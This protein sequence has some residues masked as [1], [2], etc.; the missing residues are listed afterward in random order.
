MKG[1]VIRQNRSD[2][3]LCG[4]RNGTSHSNAAQTEDNVR[5]RDFVLQWRFLLLVCE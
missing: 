2:E 3:E 4:G 5:N 1:D